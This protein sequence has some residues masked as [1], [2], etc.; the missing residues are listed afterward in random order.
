MSEFGEQLRAKQKM[1]HTYG[2]SEKQFSKYVKI[3]MQSH[4]KDAATPELSLYRLLEARLDNVVFRT[5]LATSRAL[6]R[7][8]V[9]HGHILINNRRNTVASTTVKNGDVIAIREGSKSSKLFVDAAETLG[10]VTSPVWM[11]LDPKTT[12]ATVTGAP[13]EIEAVFDYQKVLEYYSR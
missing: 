5:G 2:L 11:T 9:S 8:M 12:S 13:R 3:A 4:G 1:R 10:K 7:Q 6:A